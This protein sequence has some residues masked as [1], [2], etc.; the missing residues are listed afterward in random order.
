M[1]T[2]VILEDLNLARNSLTEQCKQ[3]FAQG[4]ASHGGKF[5]NSFFFVRKPLDKVDGTKPKR[6]TC[7]SAN[8]YE[9]GKKQCQLCRTP[10][11]SVM[12]LYYY[13][14]IYYL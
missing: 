2:A 11:W 14:F 12:C 8:C 5:M 7:S 3:K 1:T 13:R 6:L 9:L 10:Y 4:K